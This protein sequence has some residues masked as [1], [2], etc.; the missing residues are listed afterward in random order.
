MYNFNPWEKQLQDMQKQLAQLQTQMTNAPPVTQINPV[1]NTVPQQPVQQ[2]RSQYSVPT[3]H[4]LDGAKS[5]S[6]TMPVSSTIIAMDA[7]ELIFYF[8]ATDA[9][10]IPTVIAYDAVKREETPVALPEE[11]YVLKTDY[12]KLESKVDNL[13]ETVNNLSKSIV[14]EKPQEKM[15][16]KE[17][18]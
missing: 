14:A 2:Q 6:A 3:V 4:G 5:F 1:Q 8:M 11:T 10:G 16:R 18:K 15:Q 17:T 12:S 7:D 13:T 9:N